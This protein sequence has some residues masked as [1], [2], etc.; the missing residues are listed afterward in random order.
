MTLGHMP[1]QTFLP[2]SIFI[3]MRFFKNFK[4]LLYMFAFSKTQ[5]W[6]HSVLKPPS[7][8]TRSLSFPTCE[9]ELIL[10]ATPREGETG[11]CE[12]YP[13]KWP[14]AYD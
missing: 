10:V 8:P 11:G 1:C 14:M 12:D 13:R 6:P 4:F 7:F 9:P 5:K 3:L 2:N